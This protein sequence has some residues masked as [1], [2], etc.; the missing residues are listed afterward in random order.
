MKEKPEVLEWCI[1]AENDFK[2]A[3]DLAE[4]KEDPLPDLVC[5]HCQQ[6][7]EKYFKAFLV[8]QGKSPPWV[9][10]LES[11][12]DLCAVDDP[13]LENIRKVIIPLTP[14]AV[15][16]RYPGEVVTLEEAEDA[17]KRR[18]PDK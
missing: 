8:S 1:K 14:Y 15:E 11:L 3:C 12:L 2:A 13:S 10:D 18:E 17:L 16:Y 4:R 5:Y 6:A 9:H 7:C